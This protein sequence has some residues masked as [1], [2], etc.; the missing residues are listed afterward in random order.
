MGAALPELGSGREGPVLRKLDSFTTHT[1][2][3]TEGHVGL[4]P[5]PAS[6]LQRGEKC[7]AEVLHQLPPYKAEAFSP[8]SLQG[9]LSY[10]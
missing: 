6:G 4:S 8:T 7:R 5:E 1:S 3:H 2:F 10:R 9:A